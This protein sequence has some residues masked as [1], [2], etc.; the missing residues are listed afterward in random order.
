MLAAMT[1]DAPAP[2]PA[3][4]ALCLFCGS[5]TGHDPA[6]ALLAGLAGVLLAEAGVRL[7]YGGGSL[8]LMGVAATY[9]AKLL[10][11]FRW[12]GYIGLVVVLYVA[13]HMIWDGAR[14]VIVRT[15]NT[16]R[17]NAAAPALLDIKPE[18]VAKHRRHGGTVD[19]PPPTT[20]A[21][22]EPAA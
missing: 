7:V 22:P 15:D 9:I 6:H 16:E 1:A 20:V 13:L 5:R 21:A 10:H 18:E 8:G 2:R 3:I 12:I 11:R 19:A 17:F 14:Q 4:E